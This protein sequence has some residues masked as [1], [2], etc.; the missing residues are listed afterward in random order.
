MIKKIKKFS[1]ANLVL[2]LKKKFLLT[3]RNPPHKSKIYK[4]GHSN[5]R[6][7]ESPGI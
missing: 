3:R 5:S 6:A 7:N 2:N 4:T 1:L